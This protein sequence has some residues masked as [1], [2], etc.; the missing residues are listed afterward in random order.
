M[1]IVIREL[2]ILIDVLLL[3]CDCHMVTVYCVL[4]NHL[5]NYTKQEVYF[6]DLLTI[7]DGELYGGRRP[8]ASCPTRS[9]GFL[10]PACMIY[11]NVNSRAN[12]N[13]HRFSQNVNEAL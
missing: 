4:W 11:T 2:I 7:I 1:G 8:G 13:Y 12:Y 6:C 9:G 10:P 5:T 3:S